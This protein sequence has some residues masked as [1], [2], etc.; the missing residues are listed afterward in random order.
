MRKAT[1]CFFPIPS[2]SA[3]IVESTKLIRDRAFASRVLMTERLLCGIGSS[4]E[5]EN[6]E[7][8]DA[9]LMGLKWPPS[10]L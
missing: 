4:E 8:L 3:P 2:L 6:V 9:G 10:E 7:S 5:S 1:G